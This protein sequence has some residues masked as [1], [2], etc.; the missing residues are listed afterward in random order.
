MSSMIRIVK[1]GRNKVIK[2]APEKTVQQS[3]RE[4]ASTVKSWIADREKRQRITKF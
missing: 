2:D 4:I 3:T 1:P